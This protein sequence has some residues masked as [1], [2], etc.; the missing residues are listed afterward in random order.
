MYQKS[1]ERIDTC[2]GYTEMAVRSLQRSTSVNKPLAA[3]ESFVVVD[4]EDR[5]FALDE[6]EAMF[7]SEALMGCD[8]DDPLTELERQISHNALI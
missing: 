5:S 6:T 1:V 8:D 2:I 7:D 3:D 4:N